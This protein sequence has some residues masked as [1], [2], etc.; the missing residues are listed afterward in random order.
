MPF[1][2]YYLMTAKPDTI[3]AL[4]GALAALPSSWD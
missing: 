3:D 1:V 2:R 4:H